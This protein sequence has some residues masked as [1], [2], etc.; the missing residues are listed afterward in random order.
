[1]VM[2]L[3][4]ID[5]FKRQTAAA[6]QCDNKS[7]TAPLNVT[8]GTGD[9]V[10]NSKSVKPTFNLLPQNNEPENLVPDP[11]AFQQAKN[12]SNS[13]NPP[14]RLINSLENKNVIEPTIIPS[15]K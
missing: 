5:T 2:P 4:F 13:E 3:S 14:D 12:E 9:F 11:E 10:G 15:P 8:T 7:N 1:M 6:Q